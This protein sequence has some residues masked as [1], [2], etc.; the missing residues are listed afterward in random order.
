MKHKKVAKKE[1]PRFSHAHKKCSHQLVGARNES[2]GDN[3]T[4]TLTKCQKINVK[5]KNPFK[6]VKGCI[7]IV[8]SQNSSRCL[9]Q[10]PCDKVSSTWGSF[11][12]IY[13]SPSSHS[14]R[15]C[16]ES[17]KGKERSEEARKKKPARLK[18]RKGGLGKRKGVHK[19][20]ERKGKIERKGITARL[21][22]IFSMAMKWMMLE[23]AIKKGI[24]YRH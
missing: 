8:L 6:Q 5:H 11:P 4:K 16:K 2:K 19:R 21:E 10:G 9:L 24:R 20:I 3:S 14:R 7:A 22:D 23:L 18:T 12:S 13:L 15:S 1:I 17:Q